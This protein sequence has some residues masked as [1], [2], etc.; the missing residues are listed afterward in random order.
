MTRLRFFL[1]EAWEMQGRDVAGG[2]ASLTALTAVLFLLAVVLLAG[3]NIRGAARALEG[4]KGLE[5]FLVGDLPEGRV[6]EMAELF[7]SFG[8][9]AE[10]RFVSEEQELRRIERELGG[11]DVSEAMGTNPLSPVFRI[12]LTPEAAGR[13]GVVQGLAEEIAVYEGVDEVLYGEAWIGSLER[14]LRHVYWATAGA[15]ILASIAVLLVLWNTIKLAFLGRRETIRILKIVGATGSFIRM[16][17]LLLGAMHATTASILALLFA[18]LLRWVLVAMMPGLRFLPL[19]WTVVFLAGATLLGILSS[20]ASVESP[21][22]SL[23][24]SHEAVTS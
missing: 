14:G 24:R 17:Y 7:R 5:V 13:A 23:E 11:V 9:V 12:T 19:S 3:H 21:L 4:R 18:A 6:G 10:V 15:G 20:Y 2:L 22:R 8:E 16:P 1:S